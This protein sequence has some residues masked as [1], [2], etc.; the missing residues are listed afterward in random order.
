[1]KER[2]WKRAGRGIEEEEQ[3]GCGNEEGRSDGR[4]NLDRK[5]EDR[6]TWK[7]KG[8]MGRYRRGENDSVMGE[9]KVEEKG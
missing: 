7:M 5:T 8:Q 3:E 6:K 2:E 4:Q 9:G 1:M